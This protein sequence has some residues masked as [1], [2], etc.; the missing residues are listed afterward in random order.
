MQHQLQALATET[1]GVHGCAAE[2]KPGAGH[3]SWLPGSCLKSQ[4]QKWCTIPKAGS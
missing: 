4:E 2:A 1:N 3:V